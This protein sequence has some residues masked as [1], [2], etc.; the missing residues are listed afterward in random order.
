MRIGAQFGCA[1]LRHPGIRLLRMDRRKRLKT[2]HYFS[3]LDS[4][5]LAF[6][7]LWE[8]TID[9]DT[10]ERMDSET[11]IRRARE[12]MDEPLP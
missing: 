12:R 2:P 9:P 6:A 10:K 4:R 5:P 1:S 8:S 3:A 11:I 7:G